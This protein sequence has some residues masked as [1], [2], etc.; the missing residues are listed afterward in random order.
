[1][2]WLRFTTN[3]GIST[4]CPTAGGA[5]V[6]AWAGAAFSVLGGRRAK[7]TAVPVPASDITM[8]I[9][10]NSVFDLFAGC[11]LA[12]SLVSAMAQGTAKD[13]P[14][15]LSALQQRSRAPR[16]RPHDANVKK[17]PMTVNFLTRIT[18]GLQR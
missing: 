6:S 18:S 1:M 16:A 17:H 5:G 14:K 4:S 12:A 3:A 2:G 9:T 13:V 10:S 15:F 7:N 11:A 8:T